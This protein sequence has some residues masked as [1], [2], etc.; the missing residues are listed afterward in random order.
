LKIL[1][2]HFGEQKVRRTK[3]FCAVSTSK[4]GGEG[5]ADENVKQFRC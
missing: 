3:V 1:K 4:V 2:V 5:L